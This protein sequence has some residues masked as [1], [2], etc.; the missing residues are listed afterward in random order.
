VPLFPQY[1]FVRCDLAIHYFQVRY[2]P[3]VLSFVTAGTDP[4]PVPEAIIESILARCS[5]G[6]V[7]LNPK[8]FRKGEP[9]RI[10]AGPFRGFDAVFDRYLSGA[11]RVAILLNAIE[12]FNLR[13]IASAASIAR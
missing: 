13:L 2:A 11:D 12:G 5:D 3:G 10:V 9:V 4:L 7:H 1:V 8:T 6:V